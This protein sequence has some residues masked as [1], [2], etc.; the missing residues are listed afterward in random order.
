MLCTN[1]KRVR[2]RFVC[3]FVCT[4]HGIETNG[5]VILIPDAATLLHSIITTAI[6]IIVII[7]DIL[8]RLLPRNRPK[9]WSVNVLSRVLR[10]RDKLFRSWLNIETAA[11]SRE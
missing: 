4:L 11:V 7:F 6:W 1:D 10:I 8:V 5:V 2:Y 3:L 9:R